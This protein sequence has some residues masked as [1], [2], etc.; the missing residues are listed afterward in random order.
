MLQV[1]GREKHDRIRDSELRNFPC[2]DLRTIDSLWIKYSN[3]RF[4]FS[5]QKKIYLEVGGVPDGNFNEEAWK[6][7]GER[8]GW[9][10]NN[11][12]EAKIMDLSFD[13]DEAPVGHRPSCRWGYRYSVYLWGQEVERVEMGINVKDIKSK[14]Y[15]SLASRLVK[16]NL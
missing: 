10:I 8:V 13:T 7:L 3:G 4:G 14:S 11:E 5:V 16:C 6:K 12:R 15:S 1:V 9:R 2:T